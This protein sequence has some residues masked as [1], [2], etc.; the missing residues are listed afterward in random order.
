MSLTVT[1]VLKS[2]EDCHYKE[3]SGAFT[4]GGAKPVCGHSDAV[5]IRGKGKEDPFSWR[6]RVLKSNLRI[7]SWCPLKHGSGY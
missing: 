1:V 5:D 6:H 2:C 4:P 7:P 3:H